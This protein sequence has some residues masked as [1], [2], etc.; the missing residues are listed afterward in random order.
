VP[1]DPQHLIALRARGE[2][3]AY[4]P[5]DAILYALG[6]GFGHEPGGMRELPFVFEGAGLR[7]APTFASAI[8]RSRFLTGCGWDEARI[9][10]GSESLTLF[11]PMLPEAT[12]LLDSEVTAVHDL[13]KDQGALIMI[14]STAHSAN[15]E[16][17]LF[18]L[19]RGILAQGDGGFG[20]TLGTVPAPHTIPARPA[21]LKCELE[22][23]HEQ[24]LVYRLSG[25]LNPVHVDAEAARRAGLPAPVL[26]S[27]C[28]FGVACRGVLETI[29]EFDPTLITSF[30]ARYTENVFPG[31]RLLLELWQ[32]A[33]ILSFRASVPFRTKTVLDNGRC[34]LAS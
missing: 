33:N 10:P 26:H 28:T 22:I 14:R 7:V 8:A 20:A 5:R 31:D 18:T 11:R 9:V 24:A 27:L 23:R 29:C 4:A 1:I 15:D 13:G 12:L 21:D 16:H 17:P 3:V 2:R 34:V 30:E 32:D 19:Q 25:E 6:I